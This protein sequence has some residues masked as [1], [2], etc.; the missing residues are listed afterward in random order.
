LDQVPVPEMKQ[1]SPMLGEDVSELFDPRASLAKRT[2]PGAP[3]PKNIS[4]RIK[5][6]QQQLA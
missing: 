2:A 4:A 5:Y 3:S 1:I 6:W